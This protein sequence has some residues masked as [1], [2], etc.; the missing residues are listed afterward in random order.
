MGQPVYLDV[1]GIKKLSTKINYEDLLIL[2]KQYIELYNEIPISKYCNSKHN[3]PQN[4]IINKILKENN[5]L[6]KDFI[7]NF[8]IKTHVR[9][10]P[11]E[12]NEYLRKYKKICN[13]IGRPLKLNELK[14][15]NYGLPNACYFIKYC[16]NKNVKTYDDFVNMCGFKS[17][18][19]KRNKDDIISSLIKY[20]NQ[21]G[22]P[23]T[24]D[25][26]S[27]DKI[28]FSMI[29]INR[30]FGGLNN[31]KKEIGLLKTE[32]NKPLPFEYYKEQLDDILD[33]IKKNTN[34]T[35][36]SWK[37]IEN[38]E[39]NK[40]HIDHKTFLKSF[41]NEGVDLNLYIKE[42]GF[43]YK[44]N[45]FS[46]H[47]LFDDGERVL[48]NMEFDFSTYLRELGFV[49]NK[50]YF[51]DIPYNTF[52]NVNSKI[53]CDY[54]III[55]NKVLYVEI[56]GIIYNI[57]D[58]QWK[59]HKFSYKI[60]QDYQNKMIKKEK[61]LIDNGKNFLFLFSNDMKNNNYKIVFNNKIRELSHT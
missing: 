33:N 18:K 58:S 55:N 1:G 20:E 41:K 48:S 12:Y 47:Y 52:S 43:L 32:S 42:K 15:N 19:L 5:V 44:I 51:R 23:I 31:A 45:D 49:Y 30:I 17:N 8:G 46:F 29:V 34:K 60:A 28:G 59:N 57:K 14:D 53:N 37:D 11:C 61:I 40:N 13:E 56:A 36:V 7:L 6:Y 27:V 10:N 54:K 16:G 39:Y 24:K 25:D 50:D 38:K 35:Y 3:L 22:R 2:Y 26:I 21:L 9:S 4:R